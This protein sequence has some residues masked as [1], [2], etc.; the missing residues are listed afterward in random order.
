MP[1]HSEGEGTKAGLRHR[2]KV[3]R[4]DVHENILPD[5]A[6]S[7]APGVRCRVSSVHSR[8]VGA[9]LDAGGERGET[10]REET[11]ARWGDTSTVEYVDF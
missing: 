4:N 7:L 6:P 8:V 1:P 3:K 2:A 11:S 10:C 5:R 9:E